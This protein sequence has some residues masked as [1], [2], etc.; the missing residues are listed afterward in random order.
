[1]QSASN[2]DYDLEALE[3][4]CYS[5][6]DISECIPSIKAFFDKYGATDGFKFFVSEFCKKN[7]IPVSALED[8]VMKSASINLKTLKTSIEKKKNG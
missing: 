6:G 7:N 3:E 1:M 2:S 8:K 5:A 4:T